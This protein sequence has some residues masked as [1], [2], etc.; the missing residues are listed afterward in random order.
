MSY[1]HVEDLTVSYGESPVLWDVDVD[2]ERN[3]ITAIVGPNGAGKSTLL[4]CILGFIKSISGVI[5][6]D[7][8]SLAEVRKQIAYIPQVS[9][10]NWNF[11]IRVKDVV[12]M[13]RYAS[14][15]WFK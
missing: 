11:P 13:G 3:A 15:G 4:K 2:I 8:K 14:L 6:I 9:A 1:I 12:L 10:V 5:T 7:G